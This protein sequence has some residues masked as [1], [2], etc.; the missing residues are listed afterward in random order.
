[1]LRAGK[2]PPFCLRFLFSG[3]YNL[4]IMESENYNRREDDPLPDSD[5]ETLS[6]MEHAALEALF[7]EPF[8]ER[9]YVLVPAGSVLTPE[10]RDYLTNEDETTGNRCVFIF[11]STVDAMA[12]AEA[13][14][15][16][17]EMVLEPVPCDIFLLTVVDWVQYFR[18]NGV[19]AV[20]PIEDYRQNVSTS[21]ETEVYSEPFPKKPY[22]LVPAVQVPVLA[23]SHA[24]PEETEYIIHKDIETENQ[25]VIIFD[26]IVDAFAVA[27]E[28]KEATGREAEPVECDVYSLEDRFWVKFYRAN[29]AI[30]MLPVTEYRKHVGTDHSFE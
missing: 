20:M 6:P 5:R 30:K 26:S 19:V 13:Y 27:D 28:Y 7:S 12:V 1:M 10:F 17:T 23:G 14:Q 16:A 4:C 24:N 25:C 9:P 3:R 22:A 8:A 21:S 15:Q 2:F 11:D 18:S 29:G